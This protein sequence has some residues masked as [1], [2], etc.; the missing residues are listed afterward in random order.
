[1]KIPHV[2]FYAKN[3]GLE[4]GPYEKKSDGKPREGRIALRFFTMESS[5]RQVRFV[6]EPF[7]G[8][9]LYRIITGVWSSGGKEN[10]THK[11]A[12]SDG[13]VIT[14]LQVESY[15]RN[16]RKGYA[17]GIQRGG[18]A[19]NVPLDEDHFLYAA[20]FLR[21]LSLSQAWTEQRE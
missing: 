12:G 3:T 10:L 20:E 11:F 7:E 8:F 17:I 4:I 19:I 16:G 1:M 13:E 2:T 5:P 14:R 9:A 21:H 6:A 18:E 15:E